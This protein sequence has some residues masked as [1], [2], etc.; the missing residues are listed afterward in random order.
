VLEGIKYFL[1]GVD[2]PGRFVLYL[3]NMPVGSRTN[4][5]DDVEPA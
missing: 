1:E 4:L 3:P 5:L 2:L